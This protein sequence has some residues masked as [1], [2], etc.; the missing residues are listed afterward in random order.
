MQMI[1]GVSVPEY[2]VTHVGKVEKIGGFVRM[3]ICSQEGAILVPIYRAVWPAENLL[4]R[5]EIF[6]LL[7]ETRSTH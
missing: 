1:E 4:V 2:F 3:W 5:H 7:G 6:S